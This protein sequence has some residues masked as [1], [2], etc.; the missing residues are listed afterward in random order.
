MPNSLLLSETCRFKLEPS[1]EQVKIFQELFQ[2][3]SEMVD[4]C[5]KTALEY[6]ITSRKRLHKAVYKELRDKHPNFPSHYIHTSITLA[7]A[8]F[9]FQILQETF[10]KEEKDKSSQS[11]ELKDDPS[12]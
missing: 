4:L 9:K 3:Y 11:E 1:N 2:T 6:N 10:K 5:L 7:L 8:I 12:R